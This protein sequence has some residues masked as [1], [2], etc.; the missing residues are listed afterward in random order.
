MLE[1]LKKES[2]L[3]RPIVVFGA[4]GSGENVIGILKKNGI[5]INCVC[6]NDINKQK[7]VLNNYK[8]L[9][10]SEIQ[11]LHNPIVIIASLYFKEIEIQLKELGINSIVIYKELFLKRNEY[12]EKLVFPHFSNPQV[13]IV[14]TAY[15]EWRYTYECLKSILDT[16]TN[17]EYE[18]I[19]GDNAS[20]DETRN[21]EHYV[22]NAV[23]I[24]H[25]ENLGY[26][27]N[28]NETSKYAKGKYMILLSNDVKMNSD[29]WMDKWVNTLEKNNL[30]GALGGVM[31][32]WDLTN[33]D[34]GYSIG[35]KAE[36]ILNEQIDGI[37]EV[38]YLCPAC[39]CFRLDVWQEIGGF[40]E[41]F[42]PAWYE[43]LDFY[44]EM[45][46]HGYKLFLDSSVRY[47]HYGNVTYG[48]M[49]GQ[50][51]IIQQNYQ[52]FIN[53]WSKNWEFVTTT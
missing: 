16:K 49:T 42:I 10:A 53:K 37:Y 9:A 6:D 25:K 50:N 7:K 18:V 22:E 4:G 15:N 45:R 43:D 2:D 46:K 17:I 51:P 27:K 8:V 13:S 36:Y 31:Y 29:Y 21:I 20:T 48:V 28:C 3:G 52:K 11:S 41:R 34:F 33:P 1:T 26:L 30:I 44:C 19:V 5:K 14:L 32:G 12:Y 23:I 47:I 35:E 39:I 38:D 24:H 40:D